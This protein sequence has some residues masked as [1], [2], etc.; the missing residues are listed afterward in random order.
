MKYFTLITV[1]RKALAQKWNGCYYR[2][3][4]K[5]LKIGA[6]RLKTNIKKNPVMTS[7]TGLSA[8]TAHH[9]TQEIPASNSVFG[10][11]SPGRQQQP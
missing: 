8:F 9:N 6:H 7:N 3:Q 4:N 11:D 2:S 1:N 5:T 10:T